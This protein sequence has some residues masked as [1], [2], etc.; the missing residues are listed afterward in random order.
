MHFAASAQD[1]NHPAWSLNY[2]RWEVYCFKKYR[3]L[4]APQLGLLLFNVVNFTAPLLRI[5][6]CDEIQNKD[7][8]PDKVLNVLSYGMHRFNEICAGEQVRWLWNVISE[9]LFWVLY[10]FTSL[11]IR[12]CVDT[13]KTAKSSSKQAHYTIYSK[14]PWSRSV[15][16]CLAE[17]CRNG[18]HRR[19]LQACVSHRE[20]TLSGVVR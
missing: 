5:F 18:N 20:S 13:V 17:G 2:T 3:Y 11:V 8:T 7:V 16:W 1:G 6:N 14:Y 12:A 15:S 9:S 4:I 19:A 10:V